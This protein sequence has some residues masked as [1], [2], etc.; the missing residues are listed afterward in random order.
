[1]SATVATG[2]ATAA[3]TAHSTMSPP[4]SPLQP[5]A[6]SVPASSHDGLVPRSIPHTTAHRRRRKK[7]HT[8]ASS[9]SAASSAASSASIAAE[10]TRSARAGLNFPVG[11]VCRSLKSG[12]YSQRIGGGAPVYVAA[13]L[14][15]LA[16]E[17]LDLAGHAAELEY[18]ASGGESQ[19]D[20]GDMGG[21]DAAD[22]ASTA[23]SSS[24]GVSQRPPRA[25]KTILPLHIEQAIRSDGELQRVMADIVQ[26]N[27]AKRAAEMAIAA[28]R[29]AA[30]VVDRS[31]AN[32][33]SIVTS[34][35]DEKATAASTLENDDDNE[36]QA[37][38]QADSVMEESATDSEEDEEVGEDE[39]DDETDDGSEVD[40]AA[41][42]DED[43]RS[44]LP[45]TSATVATASTLPATTTADSNPQNSITGSK[46]PHS[47]LSC[48]SHSTKDSPSALVTH[49]VHVA[50]PPPSK[51]HA[52]AATSSA[53]RTK[54]AVPLFDGTIQPSPPVSTVAAAAEEAST[55]SMSMSQPSPL[56]PFDENAAALRIL[57]PDLDVDSIEQL[58]RS[59]QNNLARIILNL[60]RHG[61]IKPIT[62][63]AATS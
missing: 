38:S 34:T 47:Q 45:S 44:P 22:R 55:S 18:Q 19:S 46:R 17:I 61:I 63:Q 40:D 51:K 28:T 39:D 11:L 60:H 42:M 6:D 52:A 29:A 12:H 48:E 24:V 49:A 62:H 41:S 15:Y 10:S 23:S 58:L 50:V 43:P 35:G 7:G 27:E 26:T 53:S 9:S 4:A 56:S 20:Q 32:A 54:P 16:T 57:L 33:S 14:E 36:S 59:N 25:L 30:S 21:M 3:T 8:V 5:T 1:M 37:T 2:M 13:V 31:D